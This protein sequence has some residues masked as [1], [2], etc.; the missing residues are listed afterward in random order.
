MAGAVCKAG[1]EHPEMGIRK[2]DLLKVSKYEG[3]GKGWQCSCVHVSVVCI[4]A[5]TCDCVCG[6]MFSLTW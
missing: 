4:P 3:L 6:N 5:H 1:R 2:W